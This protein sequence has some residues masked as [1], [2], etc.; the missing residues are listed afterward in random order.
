M[1]NSH[2]LTT[3]SRAIAMLG[4]NDTIESAEKKS[5]AATKDVSGPLVHR[6]DIG[7]LSLVQKRVAHIKSIE[8]G[9]PKQ[10]SRA[11]IE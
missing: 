3:S 8:F 7:T 1:K 4:V 6:H 10:A 9:P 5:E 11:G 2:I